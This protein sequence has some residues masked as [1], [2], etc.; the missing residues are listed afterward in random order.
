MFHRLS[1]RLPTVPRIA[2]AAGG[3]FLSGRLGQSR[4]AAGLHTAT[5]WNRRP[6]K[7]PAPHRTTRTDT[8]PYW[9]APHSIVRMSSTRSTTSSSSSAHHP[10]DAAGKESPQQQPEQEEAKQQD[11]TPSYIAMQQYGQAGR[12]IHYTIEEQTNADAA[13]SSSSSSSAAV[14]SPLT[15]H[16]LTPKNSESSDSQA[17]Q[18]LLRAFFN[19]SASSGGLGDV[20]CSPRFYPL[21]SL[22][23]YFL[24]ANYPDSVNSY[25]LTYSKWVFV[26]SILGTASSVLSMQCLLVSLGL[27]AAAMP[28][29]AAINW[30]LKDG[31]GQLG[32]MLFASVVATRFDM[33]PIR[34]RLLSAIMLDASV[35]LEIFT[36]LVPALF[37]PLASLA[38]IGKNIAWLGASASRAAIHRSFLKRE[39]LADITAKAGS[40]TIL[41]SLL[42]TALGIGLSF[43]MGQNVPM[44]LACFLVL[45]A[46]HIMATYRA[47]KRVVINH[48][49]E[50]RVNTLAVHYLASP[51]TGG[52]YAEVLQ[53]LPP[54]S[55]LQRTEPLFW[56]QGQPKEMVKQEVERSS[57]SSSSSSSSSDNESLLHKKPSEADEPAP[58][59]SSLFPP[60]WPESSVDLEPRFERMVECVVRQPDMHLEGKEGRTMDATQ[61]Y[62]AWLKQ[63]DDLPFV[64]SLQVSTDPRDVKRWTGSLSWI[65]QQQQFWKRSV[66][67]MPGQRDEEEEWREDERYTQVPVD[68]PEE[69]VSTSRPHLHIRLCY[70]AS[71][72]PDDILQSMLYL[73]EMRQQW[74]KLQQETNVSATS[75]DLVK[76]VRAAHLHALTLLSNDLIK[77]VVLPNEHAPPAEPAKDA[78]S[79]AE[80]SSDASAER[81]EREKERREKEANKYK[82]MRSSAFVATLRASGYATENHFVQDHNAT[83]ITLATST[84]GVEV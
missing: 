44:I 80:A 35:L 7:G 30:V 48:L 33:S 60:S 71:A 72:S 28:V 12:R 74:Q 70:K 59:P 69:S 10:R 14:W 5:D 46:G 78:N 27:G 8:H 76:G 42:G 66:Q 40:Q 56:M 52:K 15:S 25:Y 32:G 1:G 49:T 53:L 65:A 37:L 45:S 4:V 75:S 51:S 43:G 9:R 20:L 73:A 47:L 17:K 67:K 54:P 64:A 68:L 41:A 62:N 58:P 39:N 26:G 34:Y 16:R 84:K 63:F 50:A 6:R 21:A 81:E 61:A 83:R 36:P 24:P 79:S 31:L 77:T 23:T 2:P 82:P 13:A 29:S 11:R 18:K 57:P 55:A 19:R 22:L 3:L 38:N